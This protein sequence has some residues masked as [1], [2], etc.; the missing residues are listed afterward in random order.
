MRFAM[1]CINPLSQL[2]RR[3][4]FAG[5]VSLWLVFALSTAGC[6]DSENPI[7]KPQKEAIDKR[8]F[9]T[10]YWKKGK[11]S[12]FLHIGHTGHEPSLRIITIDFSSSGRLKGEEYRAHGSVVDGVRYVN[13][14]R[15]IKKSGKTHY[16]LIKYEI[17]DG[18]LKYYKLDS[19]PVLRDI[20]AGK[21]SGD[22]KGNITA[23]SEDIRRYLAGRHQELFKRFVLLKR[24]D[25]PE[26]PLLSEKGEEE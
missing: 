8:L 16:I 4:A 22:E 2:S 19:T 5:A 21:I 17:A 6:Y 18:K 12:G 15:P 1:Y 7:S 20:K 13:I 24:A 10:W 11:K 3:A 9:G 25:L 23:S 14:H 26:S